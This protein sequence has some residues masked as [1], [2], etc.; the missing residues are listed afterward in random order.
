[1]PAYT[2]TQSGSCLTSSGKGRIGQKPSRKI[3]TRNPRK[4]QLSNSKSRYPTTEDSLT[5]RIK[6]VLRMKA[7]QRIKSF[8]K[9][10]TRKHQTPSKIMK[11]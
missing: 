4:M 9:K 7:N 3:R 11:A 6:L 2:I 8:L 5:K 10:M 1:M